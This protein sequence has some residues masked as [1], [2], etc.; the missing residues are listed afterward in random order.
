MTCDLCGS[1]KNVRQFYGYIK[2]KSYKECRRCFEIA[3][4]LAFGGSNIDITQDDIESEWN[5]GKTKGDTDGR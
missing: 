1:K 2:G 3:M 5:R 4:Q